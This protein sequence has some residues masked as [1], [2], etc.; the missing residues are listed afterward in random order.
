MKV[1]AYMLQ[2]T[3]GRFDKLDP[4]LESEV[5]GI[6]WAYIDD[7]FNDHPA[8]MHFTYRQYLKT[9]EWREANWESIRARERD[10]DLHRR[11]RPKGKGVNQRARTRMET[12]KLPWEV[13]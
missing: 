11:M 9:K 1:H 3:G 7:P 2:G 12:K 8:L 10:Y 5:P 6:P 13:T 4:K